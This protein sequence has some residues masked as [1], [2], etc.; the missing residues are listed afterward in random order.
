MVM[1]E[2]LTIFNPKGEREDDD[3]D[4]DGNVEDEQN[5]NPTDCRHL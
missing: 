4:K 5:S 1:L 2:S 3:G